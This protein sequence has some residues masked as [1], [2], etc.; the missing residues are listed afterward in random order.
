V[1]VAKSDPRLEAAGVVDELVCALGIARAALAEET[2]RAD[3]LRAQK[4]LFLIG[5]ECAAG[6]ERAAALPTRLGPPHCQALDRWTAALES[7]AKAPR[8]FVLPGESLPAAHVDFARA[9]ARRCE[10][11]LVALSEKGHLDNPHI[12]RW[13]NRLSTALWLVARV[14]ENQSHR[15]RGS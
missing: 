8:D 12:L 5:A 14:V 9:V 1:V 10:R 11:R 15:P 6:P 2:L 7:R 4:D 3:L 13:S